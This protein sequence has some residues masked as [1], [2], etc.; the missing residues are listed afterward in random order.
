MPVFIDAILKD[1]YPA[2]DQSRFIRGV[3]I[4][5]LPSAAPL[6]LPQAQRLAYLQQV[7]DA[8]AAAEKTQADNDVPTEERKRPFVLMMKELTMLG[9]FT[10]QVGATQVL[11]YVVVPGGFQ[12]CI[13]ISR[14][15]LGTGSSGLR[16]CVW[17]SK[18]WHLLMMLALFVVS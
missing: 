17:G 12:A 3:R 16:R 11:Q 1:A 7:H 14:T 18:R 5:Q 8:A 9:F 10:S 6:K 13:P 4:F 15:P 2:D